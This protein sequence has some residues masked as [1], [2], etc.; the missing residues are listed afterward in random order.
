VKDGVETTVEVLREIMFNA[1]VPGSRSK[2]DVFADR[3]TMAATEPTLCGLVE[4]LMRSLN[5]SLERFNPALASKMIPLSASP[6]GA[7]IVQWIRDN[8]RLVCLLA[9]TRDPN[10]VA[11]AIASVS[12]PDVGTGSQCAV[13][14]G[15]EV[16]LRVECHAPLAH[17]SDEKAG[18]ATLFRRI[19][20]IA[21]DG[22]VLHLP[23]YAGNAL[24]GQM[25]DLLA[26][27]LLLSLG[28]R[29]SRN[30]PPVSGWFFYCLY[31]GG[32]LEEKSDALKAVTKALGDNGATRSDG[33]RDFR[34]KLPSLSLLG[35]AL[36][37]RVIPGRIQVADLR[38]VCREWGTGDLPV[39]SMMEREFLTRRED[40]EDHIEHHGMIANTEVMRAGTVLEGGIDIDHCANTLEKA[41]LGRALKLLAARGMIGAE[42]RRGLGKVKVTVE[43]A[44]DDAPYGEFIEDNRTS[45]LGYMQDIG[46]ILT[47]LKL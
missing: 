6:D 22:N 44:P 27:D 17:G 18:N 11:D 12:L 46:A 42:N 29:A 10:L 4:R 39:A 26:D 40:M 13:R 30:R 15:F 7:R 3:I 9:M 37:N 24:R 25:R 20:A 28:L 14:T 2:A 21:T 19:R 16:T 32:A 35:C 41:A 23:Y 38:P 31:S 8:G 34:T 5:V 36:G 1:D 43:N 33:I 47:E 45:I